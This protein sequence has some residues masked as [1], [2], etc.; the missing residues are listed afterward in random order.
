[1]RCATAYYAVERPGEQT[2]VLITVNGI[3]AMKEAQRGGQ[4][5]SV[6]QISHEEARAIKAAREGPEQPPQP[7]PAPLAAPDDLRGL[8]TSLV[9]ELERDRQRVAQQLD[10]LQRDHASLRETVRQ[11]IQHSMI[12]KVEAA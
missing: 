12:T 7:E 4:V 10:A 6:R 3:D 2:S 8:L 1:M 11:I 9:E 5:L